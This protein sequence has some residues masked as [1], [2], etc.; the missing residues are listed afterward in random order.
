[1]LPANVLNPQPGMKVLDMCAAPGG[2]TTH[3]AEKMGNE[4]SIL[5]MDLHPK[6]LDLIDENTAR[7]GLEIVQTA[8]VD[9]RKAAEFLVTESYDAILVDAPCSGL[10]VMKRKPD[11]KYTKREE[12]LESL[13]TI[14]LAILDNAV[15]LLKQ[16]GRLVYS[17]CTV[18]KRENE[19]TVAKFLQ[20][21]P[22]ME[23]VPLTNL[24]QMLLEKQ[25]SGM[26]QVFP[27]DFGSDG[28]FVAAFRKKGEQI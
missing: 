16:E 19:G 26:L 24:P 9:G 25:N 8:P 20:Q 28:F 1:M 11:I 3:M 2:K 18:D 15:K 17:T 22:E 13:Q 4:G 14:Q 12:D 23:L 5:A 6:K 21:H 10:G 27:Q 7:L